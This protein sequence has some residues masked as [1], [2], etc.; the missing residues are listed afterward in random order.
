LARSGKLLSTAKIVSNSS[1]STTTTTVVPTLNPKQIVHV[2]HSFGSLLIFGLLKKYGNMSNGALLTGFLNSTQLG[3][4]PVA[5]FEHAYA[6]TNDPARFGRFGSGYVV[7]TTLNTLQKL[8]FTKETLDTELLNYTENIKQPEP[9]ALY[10][11]GAQVFLA[12]D[13]GLFK[14]PV[15]V[16]LPSPLCLYTTVDFAE[17]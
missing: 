13:K 14:G 10:A 8:Y 1:S 3:A 2:G 12:E 15:Q 5:T 9:V 16:H 4:V 7:L 11:S 17:S 6:A